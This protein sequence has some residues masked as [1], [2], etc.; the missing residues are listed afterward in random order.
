MEILAPLSE[1]EPYNSFPGAE[2]WSWMGSRC[3]GPRRGQE[4]PVQGI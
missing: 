1:D 4:V 2:F 3:E